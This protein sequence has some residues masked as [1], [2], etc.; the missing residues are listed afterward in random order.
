[1]FTKYNELKNKVIFGKY[2]LDRII[3]MGSFGCVFRG[4]NIKDNSEVAIKSEFKNLKDHLLELE[5]NF[6]LLLKGYG[7]PDVKS[8]GRSGQFYALVLELL[9]INIRE[10][11]N[12]KKGFSLKDVSM[13]AIQII[14]RIEYVHSKYIL[15]RDIKP[16]N[17]LLGYKNSSTIYIIDFGISKKYR[18]SR[19]GKHIRYS[20]TGKVFGTIKFCSYNALRGLEQ[21]RRDDLESIGNMLIY[22]A[23]GG[24]P[25]K[26]RKENNFKAKYL[27]ILKF[28]KNTS[29]KTLCQDLP[30]EFLDYIVY[31]KNL[32]FE[33]NPDYEYLR[34][35]FRKILM[36]LNE[37]NDKRFSSISNINI[38]TNKKKSKDIDLSKDKYINLL[39]RKESSH[40]R[41]YRAIQKSLEKDEKFHKKTKTF[42]DIS[43]DKKTKLRDRSEDAI[44]KKKF[45]TIDSNISKDIT[46]FN[47]R[48][49]MYNLNVMEFQEDDNL[50]DQFN[51]GPINS[52]NKTNTNSPDKENSFDII[53]NKNNQDTK[54]FDN[55]SNNLK[56]K[57]L[58]LLLKEKTNNEKKSININSN[59]K[60]K[61][62][63]KKFNL[64]I[65]L[66]KNFF[67]ETDKKIVYNKNRF[68]SAENR[69]NL[70]KKIKVNFKEE[71]RKKIC[72]SIYSNIIN[73]IE[74]NFVYP[75]IERKKEVI[76]DN[77]PNNSKSRNKKNQIN[78]NQKIISEISKSNK[79]ANPI[80]KANKIN[81]NNINN[82]KTK[83]IK[84]NKAFKRTKINSENISFDL[85][86]YLNERKMTNDEGNVNIIINNNL[87]GFN[88]ISSNDI[89]NFQPNMSSKKN[90]SIMNL[91]NNNIINK[92]ILN[93]KNNYKYYNNDDIIA[94]D[95]ES[96][97]Y[98]NKIP[99]QK[100]KKDNSQQKQFDSVKSFKIYNENNTKSNR[101]I[102]NK[103]INIENN[104]FM[105]NKIEQN[106][107]K[108]K[109]L[110]YKSIH[111]D[112][113]KSFYLKKDITYNND[114]RKNIFNLKENYNCNKKNNIN[115]PLLTKKMLELKLNNSNQMRTPNRQYKRDNN[116]ELLLINNYAT[117]TVA[118]SP[119]SNLSFVNR[120]QKYI[121][122]NYLTYTNSPS[123]IINSYKSKQPISRKYLQKM[124]NNQ[125]TY[126]RLI[127]ETTQLYSPRNAKINDKMEYRLN[128]RSADVKRN[129]DS[130]STSR[131]RKNKCINFNIDTEDINHIPININR[132][133]NINNINNYNRKKFFNMANV[134]YNKS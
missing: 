80:L 74:M 61:L 14:D 90:D 15:H 54:S 68:S 49:V 115:D 63:K 91:N 32:K 39:H 124:N 98:I 7:I 96:Y 105:K 20:K 79:N 28:K 82:N 84:V 70:N 92:N 118:T 89:N 13:L 108:I 77:I 114:N 126:K 23:K 47:S 129:I 24:F 17:F 67:D 29:P 127:G 130:H 83:F 71:K 117:G 37:I 38:L 2:R 78:L 45:S 57:S 111:N 72:K 120:N 128:N 69:K 97:C 6:L 131:T 103:Y 125:R 122:Y 86:N 42:L 31:C 134:C 119:N 112:A 16:E 46:S 95:Y 87:N 132:Y 94:N 101:E 102:Q 4:T 55:R 121:K 27:Q 65:D 58:I 106:K 59:A 88:N 99:N 8:Y 116:K 133:N 85:N 26:I 113:E 109:I 60:P 33:E 30:N 64:S 36:N 76:I 41:L 5:C 51:I 110:E 12:L 10:L 53:N 3:G 104:N 73:K 107:R 1:M 75:I 21:S 52:N 44:R 22:L 50:Y 19:T 9:G 56:K 81:N 18:S 93:K 34:N 48:Y 100:I 40:K 11:K 66:D 35:L 123:N 62:Y 43:S 25:W